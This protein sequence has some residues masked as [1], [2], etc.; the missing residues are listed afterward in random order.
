M[1]ACLFPTGRHAIERTVGAR[2]LRYEEVS[3]TAKSNPF[4]SVSPPGGYVRL[5]PKERIWPTLDQGRIS[6]SFAVVSEP[7]SYFRQYA[8]TSTEKCST[9]SVESA[10][11][12]LGRDT[13]ANNWRVPG[14]TDFR[15]S[16][17][18]NAQP[19]DI[20]PERGT[21]CFW[22]ETVSLSRNM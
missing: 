13:T 5:V 12:S 2:T 8:F 11:S 7:G 10:T 22:N 20:S 17:G 18:R 6:S 1:T 21:V 3:G 4:T 15:P 19:N 16:T 14:A 9:V